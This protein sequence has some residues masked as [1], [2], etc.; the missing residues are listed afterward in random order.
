MHVHSR[1]LMCHIVHCDL[2]MDN[3]HCWD[4]ICLLA[5]GGLLMIGVFGTCSIIECVAKSGS[6]S[7]ILWPRVAHI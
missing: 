6:C 4:Y 2:C 3:S 5:G 1:D 7:Y